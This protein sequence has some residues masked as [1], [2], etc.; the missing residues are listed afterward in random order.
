MSALSSKT[1]LGKLRT[2]AGDAADD[3]FDSAKT[4]AQAIIS[5]KK[6][7][8]VTAKG[9]VPKALDK[10]IEGSAESLSGT[11]G[12][13]LSR[14]GESGKLSNTNRSAMVDALTD[15]TTDSAT[16]MAAAKAK[17]IALEKERKRIQERNLRNAATVGRAVLP[18]TDQ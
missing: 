4:A 18:L 14:I 2:I 10:A 3:L 1:N 6:V 17:R 5:G 15:T 8:E 16:R 11:P 7:G 13:V 12:K 9:V